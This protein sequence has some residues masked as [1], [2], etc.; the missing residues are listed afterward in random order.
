ML[1]MRREICK[2][3]TNDDEGYDGKLL[4]LPVSGLRISSGKGRGLVVMPL[5]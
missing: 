3:P 1:S 2:A 5:G 4:R